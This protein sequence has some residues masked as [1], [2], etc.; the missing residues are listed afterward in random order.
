LFG[1]SQVQS[2]NNNHSIELKTATQTIQISKQPNLP[3]TL[4][5]SQPLKDDDQNLP[6]E[7]RE[8]LLAIGTVFLAVFT[9]WLFSQTKKLAISAIEQ[10]RDF[11]KHSKRELRAYVTIEPDRAENAFIRQDQNANR[12]YG[13]RLKFTN[14]GKT[15]AR[16]L[17]FKV[18]LNIFTPNLS[19]ANFSIDG[20]LNIAIQA[21]NPGETSY[22]S[23]WASDYFPQA[24]CDLADSEKLVLTVFGEAEFEDMFNETTRIKF[25]MTKHNTVW[26]AV[27][28]QNIL[29]LPVDVD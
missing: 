16:N 7:I 5:F 20:P 27:S 8:W 18:C 11:R 19:D 1:F 21:I 22:I 13:T 15:P 2:S 24:A 25:C 14:Y 4:V 10:G 9:F 29:T 17:K 12:K 26:K 3:I 23:V 28:D 6:K